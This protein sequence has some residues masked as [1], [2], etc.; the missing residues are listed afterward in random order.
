M[1]L[2]EIPYKKKLKTELIKTKEATT[3]EVFGVSCSTITD[4]PVKA[5]DWSGT[6]GQDVGDIT[7]SLLSRSITGVRYRN[8]STTSRNP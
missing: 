7:V 2:T 5:G 8:T 4:R 1:W 3:V 6:P